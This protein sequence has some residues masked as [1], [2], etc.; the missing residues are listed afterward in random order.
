M[1]MRDSL[2]IQKDMGG[3]PD[4]LLLLT[5]TRLNRNKPAFSYI[6]KVAFLFKGLLVNILKSY[7]EI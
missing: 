7:N 3:I 1:K 6:N 5:K 2:A 4:I